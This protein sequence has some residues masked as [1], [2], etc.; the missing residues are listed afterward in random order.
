M[1]FR[2]SESTSRRSF[3]LYREILYCTAGCYV[4]RVLTVVREHATVACDANSVSA[5]TKN[6]MVPSVRFRRHG[7]IYRPIERQRPKPRL[8]AATSRQQLQAQARERAGRIALYLI[9][10][11]S[12]DRL[13]LDRV[14]RHQSPSPLYRQGQLNTHSR[15]AHQKPELSTLLKSGT[16]YF[17]LTMRRGSISLAEVFQAGCCL[18]GGSI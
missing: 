12:S 14:G 15:T 18:P 4:G 8:E 6:T 5:D 1:T 2:A 17:A 13:F 11:M 10:S 3:A 9:V 16:F 7:G